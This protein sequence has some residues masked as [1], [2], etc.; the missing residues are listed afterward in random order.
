MA[1]VVLSLAEMAS[2]APTSGGQYR[3]FL[4]LFNEVAR[5]YSQYQHRLGLRVCSSEASK[6]AQLLHWL[7]VRDELASWCCFG[8]V[9]RRNHDPVSCLREQG[10]LRGDQLAGYTDGLGYHFHCI[11]WKRVRWKGHACVP[12]RH[13]DCPCFRVL[14]C[15]WFLIYEAHLLLLT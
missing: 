10:V 8:S 1:L 6:A 3:E 14:G 13:V 5:N 12:E 9:P 15:K 7:D 11:P 2:M 4:P